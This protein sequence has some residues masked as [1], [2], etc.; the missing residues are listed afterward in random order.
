MGWWTASKFIF[1]P[2]KLTT[3]IKQPVNALGASACLS[4]I[5]DLIDSR[6]KK[7]TFK[8]L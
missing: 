8:Y 1:C 6:W 7:V 5:A 2:C 3:F 4:K